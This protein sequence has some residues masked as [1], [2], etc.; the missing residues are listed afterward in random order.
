MASKHRKA[1]TRKEE[2][3]GCQGASAQERQKSPLVYTTACFRQKAEQLFLCVS[4][5][6]AVTVL[7]VPKG[8][9]V[10]LRAFQVHYFVASTLKGTPSNLHC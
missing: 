7:F 5:T 6:L 9:S 3:E 4:D 2:T 8:E 10:S 1:G